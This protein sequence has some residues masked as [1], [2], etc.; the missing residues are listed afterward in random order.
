LL[1]ITRQDKGKT[2]VPGT[3][4]NNHYPDRQYNTIENIRI[5]VTTL[6]ILFRIVTR[7]SG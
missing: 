1:I 2:P 7:R 5:D 6:K 4:L 3:M